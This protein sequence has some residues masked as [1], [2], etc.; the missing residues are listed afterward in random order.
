MDQFRQHVRSTVILSDDLFDQL[1]PQPLEI[2]LAADKEV[3]IV[4]NT[5]APSGAT[6]SNHRVTI[7]ADSVGHLG[8]DDFIAL[9]ATPTAGAERDGRVGL[10]LRVIA[11]NLFGGRGTSRGQ[12]GGKGKKGL[13]GVDMPPVFQPPPGKNSPKP[14][15]IVS[16]DGEDGGKGK[17][18]G[19]GAPVELLLRFPST[20]TGAWLGLGGAK[21]EGGQGGIGEKPHNINSLPGE[22]GLPGG[23]GDPGL[24]KQATVTTGEQAWRSA[25]NGA[26]VTA[27]WARLR[28][29]LALELFRRDQP[30]KA[31]KELAAAG[32][33]ANGSLPVV[34]ALVPHLPVLI[35]DHRAVTG[36][37]RDADL[38]PD[39]AVHAGKHTDRATALAIA[40]P[41][42]ATLSGDPATR[43]A[44]IRDQVQVMVAPGS[45]FTERD[46]DLRGR[47]GDAVELIGSLAKRSSRIASRLNAILAP[48]D[49]QPANPSVTVGGLGLQAPVVAKGL[50]DVLG[51]KA[52]F[53]VPVPAGLPATP[54]IDPQQPYGFQPSG[55]QATLL[56]VDLDLLVHRSVRNRGETITAAEL[57][58]LRTGAAGLARLGEWDRV[59]TGAPGTDE[60]PV[61]VDLAAVAD[62]LRGAAG[63]RAVVDLLVELAEITHV[64]RLARARIEQLLAGRQTLQI[65]RVVAKAATAS[66]TSPT[67]ADLLPGVR[68]LLDDLQWYADRAARASELL[69]FGLADPPPAVI[70][71]YPFPQ[72][73]ATGNIARLA[74]ILHS[75]DRELDL[76]ESSPL[77]FA[78]SIFDH[79]IQQ[80]RRENTAKPYNDYLK[81]GIPLVGIPSTPLRKTF[82]LATRPDVIKRFADTGEFWFD[83]SLADLAG[84]TGSSPHAE[85]RVVGVKVS[86]EFAV[87]GPGSDVPLIVTHT[88]LS[89]QRDLNGKEHRQTMLPASIDVSV[90]ADDDAVYE[91]ETSLNAPN[92]TPIKPIDFP[93]YGRGAVASWH[94]QRGETIT[95]LP[96]LESITV[97]V[98]YDGMVPEG[99]ASLRSVA[100]AG[101]GLRVGA[102]AMVTVALTGPAGPGGVKVTLASSDPA[103]VSVPSAVLVPENKIVT[104]AL[105]KVH[106]PTGAHPPTLT[107][108]TADGVTRQARP[109]VPKPARPSVSSVRLVSANTSGSVAAVAVVP[110]TAANQPGRVLVTVSP[111][112]G[113]ADSPEPR[114]VIHERRPDTL[115]GVKTATVGHQPRSLAVDPK[116]KRIYVANNGVPSSSVSMLDADTLA[117]LAEQK[118]GLHVD[119]EVDSAAGLVYVSLFGAA[120][121]LILSADNLAVKGEVVDPVRLRRPHGLA[122]FPGTGGDAM[123]Y[124]ARTVRGIPD[125]SEESAV[126]QIR[127]TATGTHTIVRSL[128]LGPILT[129]PVDVAV[130]TVHKLIFVSCL[131]G[132]DIAPAL[133]VLEHPTMKELHRVPLFSGGRAVESRSGSGLA[134]VAGEAGL[135]IV[136][137]LNGRVATRF[138]LGDDHLDQGLP[139]SIAVDQV[140][141]SAYV[142]TRDE[143]TLFRIDA[144]TEAGRVFW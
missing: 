120:K 9:S 58:A 24:D 102:E 96:D 128:N 14:P 119:L 17:R 61:T 142:G 23:E 99:T 101:A 60:K 56:P 106:K 76:R 107:A 29:D 63:D 13:N 62:D 125:E 136:D 42:G 73:F 79:V 87:A 95:V 134:Y 117:T 59:S 10:R 90:I 104:T 91:G 1:P 33:V 39:I 57:V 49:G 15:P 135:T 133:V 11:Q 110:S 144:P 41:D 116:R 53:V 121:I 4:G 84:E 137:G 19:D 38:V 118:V 6:L 80:V 138:Q 21:G 75:A 139:F 18:G 7:V 31:L 28:T 100:F 122:V 51:P 82:A 113:T 69:T 46:N 129:Q 89:T 88:G 65:Q 27:R 25:L 72:D 47:V 126:T 26:G 5:V 77:R 92:Q 78:P 71:D 67:P 127:R 2:D 140:T 35:R 124:A 30:A 103:T 98:L 20:F 74:P 132:N 85:A 70:S 105:A 37:A 44:T 52:P 66:V 45:S 83:A 34:S 94:V 111:P 64:W 86:L 50:T 114:A 108:K 143:A 97:D 36:V 16:R 32:V 12:R 109:V 68:C 131:G 115:A 48:P 123:I 8:G 93:I 43:L 141:G 22:P 3:L 130:D 112:V 54:P 81:R 55:D 40:L